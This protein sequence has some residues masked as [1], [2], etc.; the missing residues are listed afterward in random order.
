MV[1]EMT[2]TW[3]SEQK[4]RIPSVFVN[5]APREFECQDDGAQKR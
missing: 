4:G 3:Q 2:A 1:D 5:T